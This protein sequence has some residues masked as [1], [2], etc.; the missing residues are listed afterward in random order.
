MP[1][2]HVA[3]KSSTSTTS[4]ITTHL[5]SGDLRELVERIKSEIPENK[6]ICVFGG[7]DIITQ[8]IDQDLMDELGLSIIPIILGDGVPFFKRIKDWKKLE[9]VECKHYKSGIVI[10]HYRF[11]K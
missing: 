11:K 1:S 4:Y 9:L 10:L 8:F 7:G 6:D 2:S 5:Y 3:V